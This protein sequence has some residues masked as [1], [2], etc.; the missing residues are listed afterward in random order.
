MGGYRENC[1]RN[2]KPSHIT[3][4]YISETDRCETSDDAYVPS[5]HSGQEECNPVSTD[6]TDSDGYNVTAS[7]NSDTDSER[8]AGYEA[9]HGQKN[10]E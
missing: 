8:I 5:E 9:K 6:K 4:T 7:D 3:V 2:L 10:L 1:M